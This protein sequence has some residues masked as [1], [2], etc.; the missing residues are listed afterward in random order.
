MNAP[1]AAELLKPELT[2]L[3]SKKYKVWFVMPD[4]PTVHV[5]CSTRALRHDVEQT[6][7]RLISRHGGIRYAGWAVS[8]GMLG[9]TNEHCFCFKL[10]E[11]VE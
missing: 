1:Q 6:V 8:T 11:K 4:K 7:D 2:R 3:P 10:G 9:L 5:T